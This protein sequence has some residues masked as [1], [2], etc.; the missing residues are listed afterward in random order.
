M[1]LEE[2][3]SDPVRTREYQEWLKNPVTV[4]IL[5]IL[6]EISPPV[7]LDTNS[8]NLAEQSLYLHGFNLGQRT[9]L[10]LL[11]GLDMTS[12]KLKETQR[13]LNPDYGAS[14]ELKY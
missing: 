7:A 9:T 11:R 10:N 8:S 5:E 4:R 14:A 12:A 13:A 2:F 1:K 6:E 3:F